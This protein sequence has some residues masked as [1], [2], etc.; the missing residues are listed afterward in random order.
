MEI[1]KVLKEDLE[2][3]IPSFKKAFNESEWNQR[4]TD[5]SVRISLTNI[6]DFPHFYGL[7]AIKE[8]VPVGAIL[9]H[10]Q[11]FNDGKTYY[12]DELFVD[13]IFQKQ[14]IAKALYG[15]AIRELKK[16]G[17]SGAFFTTLTNS[18]AYDFY[19]SQG[20]IH[21]EDSA[22]FYHPF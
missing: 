9:G 3:L 13:P 5:E 6:F 1:K 22:V 19:K 8:G 16:L 12:I 2:K 21:L 4:W 15:G 20:A 14:G 10:V 11:T 17:V 7:I 18:S